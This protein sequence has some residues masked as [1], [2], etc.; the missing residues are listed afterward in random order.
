MTTF[1][2]TPPDSEGDNRVYIRVDDL[3]DISVLRTGEG[4]I[5]HV[6]ENDAMDLL[7]TLA[8][9]EDDLSRHRQ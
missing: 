8:I 9:Y 4:L 6:Y 5:V 7:G 2:F 3:F 1:E